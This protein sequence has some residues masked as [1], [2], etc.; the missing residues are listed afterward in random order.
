[1]SDKQIKSFQ[2][3]V[4]K[5]LVSKG[6]SGIKPFWGSPKTNSER[7]QIWCGYNDE[8]DSIFGC[9]EGMKRN[10]MKIYKENNDRFNKHC[11]E[12]I[13]HILRKHNITKQTINSVEYKS[14]IWNFKNIKQV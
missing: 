13:G 10:L 1:M 5:Y 2:K 12:Y 6:Y 7:L 3:D 8:F 11:L 9:D 4:I 14:T